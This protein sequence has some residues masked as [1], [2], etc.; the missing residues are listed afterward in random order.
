MK[1]PGG[2]RRPA[3]GAGS[4][5][6]ELLRL[7]FRAMD[8]DVEVLVEVPPTRYREARRLLAW[9]R[10]WFVLLEHRLSRFRPDSDVS[11]VN[12]QAGGG[13]VRVTG[14]TAAVLAR[15]LAL[16]EWSGGL[17][18]PAC[19]TAL[20]AS[21]YDRPFAQLL[22]PGAGRRD[23]KPGLSRRVGR[24]LVPGPVPGGCAPSNAGAAAGGP[25]LPQPFFG[26]YRSVVLNRRAREVMLPA[27][28]GLDF[29]GIAKGWAADVAA[30]VLGTVGPALVNVGG[31]LAAGTGPQAAGGLWR[32]AIDGLPGWV[33]GVAR[34]GVA[35]SGIDRRRWLRAGREWHHLLDPR[36]GLPVQGGFRRVTAIAPTAAQ[37][38]VAAKTVL[39][40]GPR[41]APG[42]LRRRPGVIA[43][44]VPEEGRPD[45]VVVL[46][47]G[48]D[49][50]LPAALALHLPGADGQRP[51]GR[52]A[53]GRG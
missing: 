21:G 25:P 39:I 22:K 29:G 48:R 2:R 35:T 34:C 12:L 5:R 44:A 26:N 4:G 50:R 11:R 32:V 23:E 10:R 51:A 6:R 7:N 20:K 33:L 19:V 47:S 46:A 9:T 43:L 40:L 42:W 49:H 14:L 30:R 38:E 18:D 31:D 15:A 8:S 3:P 28:T 27:G 17:F 52:R 41:Q 24:G 1:V 13:P 37:A 45:D 36:T 16:S 53:G